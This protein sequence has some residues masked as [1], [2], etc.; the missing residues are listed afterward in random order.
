MAAA[1]EKNQPG[2]R[3]GRHQ[4]SA[5]DVLIARWLKNQIASESSSSIRRRDCPHD[6]RARH[7]QRTDRHQHRDHAASFFN[8][9]RSCSR[10]INIST[11]PEKGRRS[12]LAMAF[13]L[14]CTLAEI[15]MFTRFFFSRVA[16]MHM[17]YTE[18]HTSSTNTLHATFSPARLINY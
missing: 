10:S 12:A 14:R 5:W 4:V 2:H 11:A 15:V 6:R 17:L 7:H 18:R 3:G 9:S 13:P 16:M 8:P 1:R